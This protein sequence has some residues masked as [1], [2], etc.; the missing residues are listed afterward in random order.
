MY[1]IEFYED[2][3]GKS[4]VVEYIKHLSTLSSKDSRINLNKIIAYMDMLEEMGT[5]MGEPMTKHLK[6]QIW[7]LRPLKNR[8]LYAYYK[9]N[10]FIIL[11]YF[12]KKTKKT[13]QKEIERAEKNLRDY[14]ERRE[15]L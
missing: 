4:E 3:N 1:E 13:P 14:M 8:I 6:G 15:E 11:H 5:R 9:G 10:K 2:K 12:V 7:E